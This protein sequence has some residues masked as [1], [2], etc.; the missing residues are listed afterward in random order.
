[1]VRPSC[2]Y[3][4]GTVDPDIRNTAYDLFL[5]L[6]VPSELQGQPTEYQ[7]VSPDYFANY[8]KTLGSSTKTWKDVVAGCYY[9]KPN[10]P[11]RSSHCCNA[12]FI[13]GCTS[14]GHIAG[15]RPSPL[16]G[17]S[18]SRLQVD[19]KHRGLKLGRMLGV[20]YLH[21]GPA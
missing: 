7:E 21:Y 18:C 17:S 13:V 14:P 11:G 15:E 2:V 3:N 8:Q 10:Y 16:T 19:P 12:G 4:K 20:S 1:M 5:G 6:L 9:V